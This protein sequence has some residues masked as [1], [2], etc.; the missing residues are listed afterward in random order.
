M[1]IWAFIVRQRRLVETG[2]P[3]LVDVTLFRILRLRSGLSVLLA[4]YAIT[5]GLFF[6]M[7]VY[8]Q[9]TL[10]LDALQTGLRIFP[11]SISLI[12]FSIVGTALSHSLVAAS[13]RARG[14]GALVLAS[15]L[16]LAPSTSS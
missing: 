11:L 7:P 13:H 14:S 8:L 9:M 16:L 3:P 6:M 5:A 1:L 15:F 12:L 10:G 4:Q 2:R